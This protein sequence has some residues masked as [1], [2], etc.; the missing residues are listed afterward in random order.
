LPS[1]WETAKILSGKP[2]GSKLIVLG[3]FMVSIGVALTI[4]YPA[5][6]GSA[7]VIL[8]VFAFVRGL[9]LYEREVETEIK[10]KKSESAKN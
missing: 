9:S 1:F 2:K 6:W 5:S 4:W 3:V 8:G 10:K 7:F